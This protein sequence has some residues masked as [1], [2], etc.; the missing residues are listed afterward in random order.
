MSHPPL[1]IVFPNA[2]VLDQAWV[3]SD[4][5][6]TSMLASESDLDMAKLRTN[7][8][9]NT[10]VS[11]TFLLYKCKSYLSFVYVPGQVQRCVTLSLFSRSFVTTLFRLHPRSLGDQT[12][13]SELASLS[14]KSL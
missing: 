11:Y 4:V 13:V 5:I 9:R 12:E 2:Q 8:A 14:Y 7:S 1:H 6:R 3:I 10:H